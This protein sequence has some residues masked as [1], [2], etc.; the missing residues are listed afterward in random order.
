MPFSF[1]AARA[2]WTIALSL[3]AASFGAAAAPVNLNTW[4][5][6]SYPAVAGFGAGV[7]NT[8]PDGSSVTQSVNGQPTLFVSDF[9]AFGSDVR[10]KIRVNSNT[11]DDYIGFA[12]GYQPGD[13]GNAAADYLLIDW[14][15]ATQFFD[16]GNPSTTPGSTAD[17]GLAVSRVTGVPT[18]DEFWGHANLDATADGLQELQRGTTLGATGWNEFTTYEFRFVFQPNSLMVFV[19]NQLELS[20]VGNFS[21]G[22][23]AFYNFSQADVTYSAFELD[24]LPPAIPEPETYALMLAGLAAVGAMARRRRVRG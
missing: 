9:N 11:D 5:A 6:E 19:D 15:Q 22:R 24:R 8:A 13:T 18:A 16:F 4:S 23:M 20:I 2:A 14:K 21:D 17:V 10:G 12:I 3:S 7:W 1:R